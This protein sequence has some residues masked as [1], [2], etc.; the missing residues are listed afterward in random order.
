MAGAKHE[1][2]NTFPHWLV[3]LALIVFIPLAA[4]FNARLSTIRQM[5]QEEAQLAREIPVEQA[6]RAQLERSL[7]YVRSDAYAEYWAR[8]EARMAYPGEV[9]VIPVAPEPAGPSPGPVAPA[10]R[11]SGAPLDEWWALFFDEPGGMPP[12]QDGLLLQ[13]TN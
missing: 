13:V 5:R 6:R 7:E 1:Q 12:D 3:A 8:V 10:A 2:V 4:D 11:P 9:I